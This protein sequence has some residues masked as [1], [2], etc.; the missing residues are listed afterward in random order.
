MEPPRRDDV[1]PQPPAGPDAAPEPY[2]V[3]F[4]VGVAAAIAGLVPWLA[5]AAPLVPGW[6]ARWSVPWPGLAHAALLVQGFELAFAC[7]FLLAGA[8]PRLRRPNRPLLM[9][10]R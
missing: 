1:K 9:P 8:W 6:P 10:R 7:G 4:P 3:L 2:R 5:M